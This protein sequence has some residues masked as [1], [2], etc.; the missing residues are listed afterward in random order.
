MPHGECL[1][2]CCLIETYSI[3]DIVNVQTKAPLNA[4]HHL[5]ITQSILLNSSSNFKP[6]HFRFVLSNLNRDTCINMATLGS[7]FKPA[8]YCHRCL[9][10]HLVLVDHLQNV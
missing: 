9:I 5:D 1:R 3:S 7:S 2:M 10:A 6:S 8:S 4:K